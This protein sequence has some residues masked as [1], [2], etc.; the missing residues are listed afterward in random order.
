MSSS[1]TE[2][3]VEYDSTSDEKRYKPYGSEKR[4]WCKYC[5]ND[6]HAGHKGECYTTCLEC[7]DYIAIKKGLWRWNDTEFEGYYCNLCYLSMRQNV[8]RELLQNAPPTVKEPEEERDVPS[9]I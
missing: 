6:W 8:E 2:E 9:C 3:V 4:Y 1:S 5:D 7:H